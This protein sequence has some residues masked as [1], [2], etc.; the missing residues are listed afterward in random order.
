MMVLVGVGA[1]TAGAGLVPHVAKEGMT[2]TSVLGVVLVLVGLGLVVLGGRRLLAGFRRPAR[3]G[4]WVLVVVF[5]LVVASVVT[6]AVA[7]TNVPDTDLGAGPASREL[8]H[9]VVGVTTADGVELAGWYLPSR[10]GTAVVLRHG[11][12]S[13]RSNVLDEAVVLARAGYGVLLVD[14]RGHGESGGRAMD[15]GWYG[16]ADTTAAVRWLRARDDVDGSRVGVVGSSMGGEEAIGAAAADPSIRAV[17]AEG[18]TARTAADRRWLSDA[19][20]LRGALQEQL[21]RLRF[22]LTDLLTDAR[23]PTPLRA[24]VAEADQTSFLLIAAGEVDGERQAAAH[25]ASAGGDRV[26]VWTVPGSGHTDGLQTAPEEWERRISAFLDT[27]L[28]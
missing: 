26:E 6:P 25:I 12:G 16:D 15:L 11:A 9:E 7:V 17:V 28:G 14:A 22:G 10:N 3:V 1:A 5:L 18:A 21:D 24:A 27:H 13:T 8:V 23:P 4:T 19:Y 20:G 2:P